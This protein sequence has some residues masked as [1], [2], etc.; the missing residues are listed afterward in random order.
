MTFG[1][2]TR[3][4]GGGGVGVLCRAGTVG[5]TVGIWVSVGV[6][7]DSESLI[8]RAHDGGSPSQLNLF[9]SDRT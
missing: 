8:F 6:S 7:E 2:L 4:K 5:K 9:V 1:V 3:G